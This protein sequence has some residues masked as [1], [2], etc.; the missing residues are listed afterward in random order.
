M[1]TYE[2]IKLRWDKAVSIVQ[3]RENCSR[4]AAVRIVCREQNDLRLEYVA[5]SQGRPRPGEGQSGNL[6]TSP[7][8]AQPAAPRPMGGRFRA[9]VPLSQF[10]DWAKDSYLERLCAVSE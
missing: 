1:S 7:P 3:R 4:A 5:A 9:S 2:D 10:P 8:P 6:D